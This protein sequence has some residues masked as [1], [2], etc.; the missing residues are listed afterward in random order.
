MHSFFSVYFSKIYHMACFYLEQW[1][2]WNHV[3]VL[4]SLGNADILSIWWLILTLCKAKDI[5]I[6]AHNFYNVISKDLTKC[7]S[8]KIFGDFTYNRIELKTNWK[9]WTVNLVHRFIFS[10]ILYQL[11]FNKGWMVI[12]F[13]LTAKM[14]Y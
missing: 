7:N 9:Q 4:M 3:I 12:N 6:N 10:N 1:A 8:R 14:S 11:G 13:R 2:I 5:I